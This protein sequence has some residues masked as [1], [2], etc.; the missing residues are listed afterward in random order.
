MTD[1]DSA[2]GHILI[3]SLQ[4]VVCQISLHGCPTDNYILMLNS[5]EITHENKNITKHSENKSKS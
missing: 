3:R 4:L 1:P 2:Q 5:I